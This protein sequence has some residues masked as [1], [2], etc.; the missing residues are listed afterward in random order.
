MNGRPLKQG[1][2]VVARNVPKLAFRNAIGGVALG[3]VGSSAGAGDAVADTG[4]TQVK[5]VYEGDVTL[6][7]S[8]NPPANPKKEVDNPPPSDDTEDNN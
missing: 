1:R 5:D 3:G 8:N 7:E 4:F 2:G 6:I